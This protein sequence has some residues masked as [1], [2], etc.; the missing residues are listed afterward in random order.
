MNEPPEDTL[1]AQC[2]KDITMEDDDP[3]A[4]KPET[5]LVYIVHGFEASIDS[6]WLEELRESVVNR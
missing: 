6:P 4:G 3:E 5:W 1:N 2:L